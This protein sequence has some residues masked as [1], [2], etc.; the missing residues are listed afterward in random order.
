MQKNE[1]LN[2]IPSFLTV[3]NLQKLLRVSK[4]TAYRLV[5]T[6]EIRAKCVGRQW[7]IPRQEF[8]RYANIRSKRGR[9]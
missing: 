2:Q 3:K 5:Q 9:R 4:D 8:E 6:G 1:E 7:R